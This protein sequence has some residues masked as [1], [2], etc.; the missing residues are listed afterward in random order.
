MAYGDPEA[1]LDAFLETTFD[2]VLK[3]VRN[4]HNPTLALLALHAGIDLA[5]TAAT[6]G[7]FD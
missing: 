4:Q 5:L 3:V 2:T 6:G 7:Y 1:A